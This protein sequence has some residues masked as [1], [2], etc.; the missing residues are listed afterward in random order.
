M[1]DSGPP[2]APYE[3]KTI[4]FGITGG[5]AAFKA[6]GLAST[7]TQRGSRVRVLMTPAATR[8]VA[9]LTFHAVTQQPV[10]DDMWTMSAASDN[11]PVHID[12]A[13]QGHVFVVAPATA[14]FLA[15]YAHGFADDVV[16]LTLLAFEVTTRVTV[17]RT[18]AGAALVLLAC[19]AKESAVVAG[20]LLPLVHLALPERE[21]PRRAATVAASLAFL[22]T[23]AG[24]VA[25]RTHVLPPAK[26]LPWLAQIAFPDGSRAAA[27]RGMLAGVAEYARGLVWPVGF[28]FDR[29]VFTDKINQ[30][31]IIFNRCSLV[32]NC[33]AT[34]SCLIFC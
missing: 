16:T 32:C 11:R 8:F 17:L 23:A 28:P 29:N 10:I 14:D 15:R 7:W 25:W 22:A 9:P 1:A 6:A 3:G 18:I 4:L 5:I 24:Y 20:L 13:E 30:L 33:Q 31:T 27:A 34:C 21:R 2:Q 12:A 19:L 26:D